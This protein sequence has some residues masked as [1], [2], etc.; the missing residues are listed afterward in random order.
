MIVPIGKGKTSVSTEPLTHRGLGIQSCLYKLYSL[1]LTRRLSIYFEDKGLLHESQN[2]FRKGRNCIEHVYTLTETIRMNLPT[3]GSRVYACFVDLKK[4]FPSVNHDLLM[5]KFLSAGVTGKMY[6]A[7]SLTYKSPQS[8]LRLPTGIS[9]FFRN[10]QGVIEGDPKSPLSFSLYLNELLL[11]L[12]NSD[13]G[14]Y[15]GSGADDRIAVLAYADDLVLIASTKEK[16]QMELDVLRKYCQKWRLSVNVSKTKSMVF[17]RNAQ[18]RH[19]D[20]SV[21]FG[22]MLVEQVKSY[23]YL[24][25]Y[26]DEILSYSRHHAEINASASRALGAIIQKTKELKDISYNAYNE[27]VRSCVFSILDYG[28]ELA[29]FKHPK[30]IDDVLHRACRYFMGLNR[31]CPLPCLTAE[32]GWM[33]GKF[34]KMNSSLRFYHRLLRMED[35]WLPKMIFKNTRNNA[36]SWCAEFREQC[37]ELG[38]LHYWETQSEIPMDIWEFAIKEKAKQNLW[39]EIEKRPKLRTYR[40]TRVGL[41]P[42][43]QVTCLLT[44]RHRS[45]ISQIKCG[46]LPLRIESGR[47][48]REALEVRICQLC[49]ANQV[50]S[51][52]HFLFDCEHYVNE[53]QELTSK[54]SVNSLN[55]LCKHPFVMGNY[56]ENIW[57]R[58][59]N[60]LI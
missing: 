58:R 46:I 19:T 33:P 45:L 9:P 54:V 27:L 12:N 8:C 17:K 42:G 40:T 30:S 53:R 23:K 34:R 25:V 21:K 2:G 7:I 3:A 55:E 39:E 16:L 29:G 36:T 44:K 59:T 6:S 10:V 11:E 18:C 31:S 1:L 38:L 32:M 4:A 51:E 13:L 15:Y 26:V 24:G 41:Q 52:F 60:S 49:D 43:S 37:E 57:K 47:Y 50:E 5:Y 35:C 28:A 48:N 22:D 20:I 56:L 14:V